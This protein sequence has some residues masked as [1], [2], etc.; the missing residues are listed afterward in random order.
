MFAWKVAALMPWPV[1]AVVWGLSVATVLGGFFALFLTAVFTWK[2]AAL[3]PLP[4]AAVWI[5]A[6]D[7][8][9]DG[10]YGIFIHEEKYRLGN[11]HR[12]WFF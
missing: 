1:A 11:P 2:V 8:V 5:M 12:Y 9:V 6:A 7:T 10:F 4:V 3:M